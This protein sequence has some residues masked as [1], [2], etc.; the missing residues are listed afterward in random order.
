MTWEGKNGCSFSAVPLAYACI[1]ILIHSTKCA[2]C[3]RSENRKG[4]EHVVVKHAIRH[5]DLTS[6][7]KSSFQL[8]LRTHQHQINTPC[9]SCFQE[10]G[11]KKDKIIYFVHEHKAGGTTM[12]GLASRNHCHVTKGFNCNIAKEGFV[13]EISFVGTTKQQQNYAQAKLHCHGFVANE[14]PLPDEL[15]Y[16]NT[17]RYVYFTMMRDP[18]LRL[19]SHYQEACRKAHKRQPSLD[20][21]MH[22]CANID[23]FWE[24]NPDNWITR[25]FCGRTCSYIPRGQLSIEE[26]DKAKA[27][28]DKMDFVLILEM[29]DDAKHLLQNKVGWKYVD[30]H[31]NQGKQ[32]VPGV[33][34]NQERLRELTL[35]DGKLYEYATLK[36]L[37]AL[38]EVEG[39]DEWR[40]Q[41]KLDAFQKLE[42]EGYSDDFKTKLQGFQSKAGSCKNPCC[43]QNVRSDRNSMR[44]L[45]WSTYVQTICKSVPSTLLQRLLKGK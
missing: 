19:R 30:K 18:L 22:K 35:L 33:E 16:G 11:T 1:L 20:P 37:K 31:S 36:F 28:L 9:G 29:F 26:L 13:Q 34:G 32:A 14:F 39:G 17:S 7:V 38:Q 24:T 15:W 23:V 43:Y 3:L 4:A 5:V 27:N 45:H 2:D 6:K 10:N 25:Q 41:E 40:Y 12:C 8:L 21:N 44:Q 42:E